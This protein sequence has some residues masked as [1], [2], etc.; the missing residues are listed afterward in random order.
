[1]A[2]ISTRI[3]SADATNYRTRLR[4]RLAF[5]SAD[6]TKAAL[7]KK[8][9]FTLQDAPFDLGLL[10]KVTCRVG[11]NLQQSLAR[12]FKLSHTQVATRVLLVLY[13]RRLISNCLDPGHGRAS[14]ACTWYQQPPCRQP[15]W[16]WLPMKYLMHCKWWIARSRHRTLPAQC[17]SPYL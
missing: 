15:I 12:S 7:G 9:R 16:S 3:C 8:A 2:E 4:T 6:A 5:A 14:S 10:S 11:Q 13:Q 17:V 1:M